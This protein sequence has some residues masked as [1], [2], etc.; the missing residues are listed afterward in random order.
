MCMSGDKG[1]RGRTY[2][3]PPAARPRYQVPAS[4][5][6]SS[7][8]YPQSS[9]RTQQSSYSS[10]HQKAPK[11]TTSG[12]SSTSKPTNPAQPSPN[13]KGSLWERPGGHS[14]NRSR[15]QGSNGQELPNYL[16]E[17]E[18]YTAYDH[19]VRRPRDLERNRF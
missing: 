10:T 3:P 11:A 1:S 13:K 15:G 4:A 14:Y 6:A 5:S 8:S 19:L 16:R 18:Q 9:R 7:S 12:S 2:A 17:E